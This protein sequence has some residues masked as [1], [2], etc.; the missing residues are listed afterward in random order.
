MV[1]TGSRV[2]ITGHCGQIT[3]LCVI[4]GK[5]C[6]TTGKL[7]SCDLLGTACLSALSCLELGTNIAMSGC[8]CE[9]CCMLAT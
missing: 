5:L 8:Q 2:E 9:G 6:V 1:R 7:G 3:E 4:T